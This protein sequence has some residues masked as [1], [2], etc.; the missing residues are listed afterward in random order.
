MTDDELLAQ[1]E[2][3]LTR[4]KGKWIGHRKNVKIANGLV[5]A[6]IASSLLVIARNSTH[7]KQTI[8]LNLL[9]MTEEHNP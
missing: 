3:Y 6:S 7:E 4:L 2:E 5:Q 8:A 1:A 9:P